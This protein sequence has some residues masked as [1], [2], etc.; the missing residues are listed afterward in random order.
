MF[1]FSSDFQPQ[2]CELKPHTSHWD[3]SSANTRVERK[4]IRL[5]REGP[6]DPVCDFGPLR[7]RLSKA[8]WERRKEAVIMQVLRET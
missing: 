1:A 8:P 4:Q 6:R 2:S 7:M 3:T 5:A